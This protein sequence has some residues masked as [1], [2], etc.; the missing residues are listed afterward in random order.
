MFLSR[1]LSQIYYEK[2]LY[3]KLQEFGATEFSTVNGEFGFKQLR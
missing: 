2:T 1:E 3:N